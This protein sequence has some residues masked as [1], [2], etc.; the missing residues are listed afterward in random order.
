MRLLGPEAKSV[1]VSAGAEVA[2]ADL[3]DPGRLAT[4]DDGS[5]A[6][7]T[8]FGRDFCGANRRL[9]TGP[10]DKRADLA[11]EAGRIDSFCLP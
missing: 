4:N 6:L 11:D 5:R 9:V 10:E 7:Y 3:D 8:S 1:E 2:L